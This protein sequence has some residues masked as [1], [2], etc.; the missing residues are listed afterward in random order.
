M[1]IIGRS[2]NGDEEEVRTGRL[3]GHTREREGLN[4]LLEPAV[5]GGTSCLPIHNIDTLT[6]GTYLLYPP[7]QVVC[8]FTTLTPSP[9]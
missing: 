9:K 1:N 7:V 3:G 2:T 6:Y 4:Y 8:P 5:Y